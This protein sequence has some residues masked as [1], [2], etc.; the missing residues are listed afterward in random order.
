MLRQIVSVATVAILAL[1]VLVACGG[2][3]GGGEEDVTRVPATGA[4]PTP[5]SKAAAVSPAAAGSPMASPAVVASPAAGAATEATAGTEVTVEMVD[6]AFNPTEFA[7]PANTDVKVTLPNKGAAPHNFNV[8][9]LNVHSDTPNGGQT[10]EVT[11]NG[12]PGT[13]EYYCA[14]PGHKQAG[15]VGTLTVQ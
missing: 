14:V 13:Y 10:V 12:A 9:E 2:D 4:P 7:I 5:T 8:D 1:A 11:I 6:I 3:E 15:M